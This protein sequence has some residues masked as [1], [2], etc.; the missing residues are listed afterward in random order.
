MSPLPPVP[1]NDTL[2]TTA[3][4]A[5]I[6]ANV[7]TIPASSYL[8]DSNTSAM[9]FF[10]TITTP[11]SSAT[12]TTLSTASN[13]FSSLTSPPSSTSATTAAAKT[14]NVST[15]KHVENDNPWDWVP[16]QPLKNAFN[17]S[18]TSS[19]STCDSTR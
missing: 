14:N 11:T 3:A 4:T 18:K 10:S 12:A 2:S 6:S 16:D 9:N 8:F 15:A 7:E 13:F 5:K 1:E 17:T 19:S